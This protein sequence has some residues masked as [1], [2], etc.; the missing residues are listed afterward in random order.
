MK[1]LRILVLSLLYLVAALAFCGGGG[2]A[3]LIAWLRSFNKR[4]QRNLSRNLEH[5]WQLPPQSAF[6]QYFAKQVLKSQALI[7]TETLVAA[8]GWAPV[9]WEGAEEVGHELQRLEAMGKGAIL[10][11]AHLGAWELV[12]QLASKLCT[13]TFHALAKGSPKPYADLLMEILRKRLGIHTLLTSEA[14][15]HRKLFGALHRGE[16]LGFVMDQK[17]AQRRGPVVPFFGQETPFVAGPAQMALK[18]ECPVIAVFGVRLGPRRYKCY[19]KV[20]YVPGTEVVP[21]IDELTAT[22][23]REIEAFVKLYPEQWCWEYKR[24]NFAPPSA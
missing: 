5:I 23:A 24:W 16:W 6:A 17:P 1:P 19:S 20:L 4:E 21:T 14:G 11:T 13:K 3:A 22:M 2:F 8:M 15:F 12:G 9:Q 7:A 10:I 18:A